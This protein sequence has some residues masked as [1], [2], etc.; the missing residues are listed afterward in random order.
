MAL[1]G[2]AVLVVFALGFE[3]GLRELIAVSCIP[4]IVAALLLERATR[5]VVVPPI[6]V[7]RKLA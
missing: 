1:I 5:L 3:L 7:A 6:P 4:T 2:P